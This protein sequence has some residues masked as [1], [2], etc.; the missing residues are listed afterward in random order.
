MRGMLVA[1]LVAAAFAGCAGPEEATEDVR[2]DYERGLGVAMAV[3]NDAN[4]TAQVVVRLH[5]ADGGVIGSDNATLE[6]GKTMVRRY[7]VH[8]RIQ[9]RVDLAYT[10]DAGG[11]AAGGADAQSFPLLQCDELTRASW[12][13]VKA[14][15]SFGSQWLG[16]TCEAAG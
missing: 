16:T 10:I 8:D 15:D 9:V 6:P 1:I 13:L 7:A 11:R 3:T 5:N 2:G 14:A 4:K 12:R